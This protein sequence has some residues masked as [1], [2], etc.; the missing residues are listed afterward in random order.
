MHPDFQKCIVFV[1][2]KNP[3]ACRLLEILNYD[4]FKNLE[5]SE[6][7][8]KFSTIKNLIMWMSPDFWMYILYVTFKNLDTCRLLDIYIGFV[9]LENQDASKLLEICYTCYNPK[10]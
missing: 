1:K 6:L 4:K 10:I 2:S 3:D 9:K 5:A 7:L 8:K